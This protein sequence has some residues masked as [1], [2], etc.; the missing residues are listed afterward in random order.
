MGRKRTKTR[1]RQREVAGT[2]PS[3]L[4]VLDT[5][6]VRSQTFVHAEL[7]ALRAAG[8]RVGV[9][10][11][12]KGDSTVRFGEGSDG[13]PFE[14]LH[15][16]LNVDRALKRVVAPFTHLHGHFA[17][18]GVRVLQ[19]LAE[20]L[21]RPFSFMAH[22]Y[23]LF[24]RD[25]AVTPQEWRSLSPR[26]R[27]VVTISRF[28][29][30]YIADRGVA[31]ERIAIV[32]NA[33]RLAG[34]MH[35]APPAP[36]ALRRV[37][38]VGRPTP[39]K[40]M[41]VLLQ[42]WQIARRTVPDL[43]LEIVGWDAPDAALPG[44]TITGMRP[45]AEV[46]DAMRRADLVVA[47]SIVAPSG[48]MD[49]IPTVLAEAGALN[50]PVVATDLSG[51]PDLVAPGVN[52][53]LVPPGCV[54][55]LATVLLRLA[56]RPDEIHRLGRGGQR[57]AACHDASVTAQRLLA[58]VF[59]P[60]PSGPRRVLVT[61]SFSSSNRG[62]AAILNGVL[63]DITREDPGAEV[64]VVSHFPEVA[65][66]FHPGLT[67]MGD[68]DPVALARQLVHTDAVVSCGGSFLNDTYALD[69]PGRLALYHAA[70]RAELP[71]VFYAQSMG[72]F[73][74]PLARLGA[75]TVLREASWILARDPETADIVR[76]LG[77]DSPVDVGVDAAV[78]GIEEPVPAE[79]HPVLG[80]TVRDW[81]FPD[82][83]DPA[84]AQ[85]AYEREVAAALDAWVRETSGRVVFFS[86]CTDFGGYRH[87]DRVCARRI[88]G[89]MAADTVEVDEVGDR[90][91][92]ALRARIG[93]CDFFLATRMHSLV[94]ATTAGVPSYGI[95][96]ERKTPGWFDNLGLEGLHVDIEDCSGLT[97]GLLGAWEARDQQ[98]KALTEA[99]PGMVRRQLDQAKTLGSVLR[100]ERPAPGRVDEG[101]PSR[102][103]EG[104]QGETFKY[105]VPHR[106]LRAVVDLVM[107]EGGERVLDVGCSTGLLGRMLGVGFDYTGIDIA[108]DV[109]VQ[110]HRFRILT[111][112]LNVEEPP[113]DT[114]F[115]T[116]VCCGSLE[117]LE[118]LPSRLTRLREAARPGALGV[119]TLYNLAHFA[120]VVRPASRHPTW[121]FEARPD[122]L[123]LFL[124]E[125]GWIPDRV[126]PTSVSYGP[127]TSVT[128]ERPTEED[129]MGR[130]G[131]PPVALVRRA[132]Q[133][134]VVCRAGEPI[135]GPATVERLAQSD[136]LQGAMRTAL[137]LV[138]RY[139]WSGRAWNDLGVLL[140]LHGD[141][142]R[143]RTMLG[144]A[145]SADPGN[146]SYRESFERVGGSIDELIARR[147]D[148]ELE[149][150]LRPADRAAWDRL[151]THLLS[152]GEVPV[153]AMVVAMR[154]RAIGESPQRRG[155]PA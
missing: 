10:V 113:I 87:D 94:F 137:D 25:A 35:D 22:A 71:V 47:P 122:E 54:R 114:E 20:A 56:S 95:A 67:V 27:K 140:H 107:S 117:Y 135:A 78:M 100:G 21:D 11:Q 120:R 51:I 90:P 123:V 58:E 126:L 59:A 152:R 83:P 46:L 132:H 5:Y 149:V 7:V 85:E 110:R 64:T 121:R 109:A 154:D 43:E 130:S 4:Y 127:S 37:L 14:V 112:D 89:R 13:E 24:R 70:N 105:D 73:R 23:D 143:A 18:F 19:P 2:S 150:L 111:A 153:A 136:D 40:G 45:Y 69:L 98:R 146:T 26:C 77:V 92:D 16:G 29:R 17:D 55:S 52:G 131:F 84:V 86:N 142:D 38:A 76:D 91:F 118:D 79:A 74:T 147:G 97:A 88:A 99:I 108:E 31:R 80:V 106:R 15:V 8:V 124:H 1:R 50:R 53:L 60:R 48:D 139:G 39:K 30:D 151:A 36:R 81:Y 72:P 65:N 63:H 128:A 32:P 119:F 61:D 33:A 104:W 125:A 6:P 62:D 75:R 68:G 66:H 101:Q 144:N 155:V 44:L 129:R 138:K 141:R 28:H 57:L 116:V 82:S 42:A 148:P 93:G 3:V 9:V 12:R 96:Y 49:G 102:N 34:L 41:N 145:V 134:V 115:D 133:V 103:R